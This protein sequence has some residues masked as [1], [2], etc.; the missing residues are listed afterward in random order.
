MIVHDP[1]SLRSGR[2][3]CHYRPEILHR[4]ASLHHHK[5]VSPPH[6]SLRGIVFPPIVQLPSRSGA[7]SEFHQDFLEPK[8]I[9]GVPPADRVAPTVVRRETHDPGDWYR[10]HRSVQSLTFRTSPHQHHRPTISPRELQTL[11]HHLKLPKENVS[12]QLTLSSP[13]SARAMFR[14]AAMPI[15]TSSSPSPRRISTEPQPAASSRR[16]TLRRRWK[17]VTKIQSDPAPGGSSS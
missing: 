8:C 15:H 16:S 17:K 9:C 3:H 13:V 14:G 6:L 10:H 1:T 12:P 11:S 2:V 5:C 4:H 7:C